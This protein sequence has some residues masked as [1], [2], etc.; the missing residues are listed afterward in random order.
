[1]RNQVKMARLA[2][3]GNARTPTWLRTTTA[4]NTNANA[5]VATKHTPVKH[6]PR[7]KKKDGQR[8]FARSAAPSPPSAASTGTLA[9][10]TPAPDC[11]LARKTSS[12]PSSSSSSTPPAVVHLDGDDDDDDCRR[13]EVL[14]YRTCKFDIEFR[15]V[16]RRSGLLAMRRSRKARHRRERGYLAGMF[17]LVGVEVDDKGKGK[18]TPGC[19]GEEG[20]GEDGPVCWD[21]LEKML[22]M[23]RET[24][25][26]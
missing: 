17:R 5:A 10:E 15:L 8:P 6:L 25:E 21:L 4:L 11:P 18:D 26:E 19:A 9:A 22:D 2:R 1:M 3:F 7:K 24:T 12:S 23:E 16:Q 13:R 14:C 20:A